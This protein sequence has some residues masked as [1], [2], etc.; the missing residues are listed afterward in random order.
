M[1]HKKWAGRIIAVA[2]TFIIVTQLFA[3]V[4]YAYRFF[5]LERA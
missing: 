2:L 1:K 3:G 5:V 4:A